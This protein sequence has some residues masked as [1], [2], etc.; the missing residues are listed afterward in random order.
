MRF[1]ARETSH[2][3]GM[4]ANSVVQQMI[5]DFNVIDIHS[6]GFVVIIGP[7]PFFGLEAWYN[8]PESISNRFFGDD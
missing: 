4:R 2:I 3:N 1:D 6:R 5:G 8:P 7:V